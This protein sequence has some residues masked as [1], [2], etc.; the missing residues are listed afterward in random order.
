MQGLRSQNV[1][2]IAVT[3][4]RASH[5]PQAPGPSLYLCVCK[6]TSCFVYVSVYSQLTCVC[7]YA[8]HAYANMHMCIRAYVWACIH[9]CT[10][11]YTPMFTQ[12]QHVHACDARLRFSG[13]A[14]VN[15]RLS[16]RGNFRVGPRFRA[17]QSR[18]HL[19]DLIQTSKLEDGSSRVI[20]TSGSLK[21]AVVG[22]PSIR[23]PP[24]RRKPY[25]LQT[26]DEKDLM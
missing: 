22:P 10:H 16:L 14:S 5:S 26:Q 18:G 2:P 6:C 20:Q 23:N 1:E 25:Q 17:A 21:M 15:C 19:Q 12:A 3:S 24:G 11:T 13:T 9:T 4:S 8:K 7:T